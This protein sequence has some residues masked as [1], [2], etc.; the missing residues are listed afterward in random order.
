MR[1]R[2]LKKLA[3]RAVTQV[4]SLPSA[5]R[6]EPAKV[7]NALWLYLHKCQNKGRE[8]ETYREFWKWFDRI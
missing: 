4:K 3:T 5:T 2:Q 7:R 6:I 1:K 8:P